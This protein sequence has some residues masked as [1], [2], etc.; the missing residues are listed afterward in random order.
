ML[1]L[2]GCAGTPGCNQLLEMCCGL[3]SCSDFFFRECNYTLVKLVPFLFLGLKLEPQ[4]VKNKYNISDVRL[5]FIIM[6]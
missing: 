3:N 1:F 5:L 4:K 6:V 2:M